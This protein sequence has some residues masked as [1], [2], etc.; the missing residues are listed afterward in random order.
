SPRS[1]SS[2]PSIKSKATLGN[3]RLAIWCR[4]LILIASFS[5]I[6]RQL[7]AA[8]IPKLAAGWPIYRR[9]DNA[10]VAHAQQRR[11]WC[12]L[13][14]G[15]HF[16]RRAHRRILRRQ[17]AKGA[18]MAQAPAPAPGFE[19][20]PDYRITFEQSPRRVRVAFNGVTVAESSA[21]HLLFETRH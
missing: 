1:S 8:R 13:A 15:R 14:M 11:A 12:S 3:R 5:L 10:E 18:L 20:N 2:P 7:P 4:S 16:E 6:S 21:A 19:T 9:A 17:S